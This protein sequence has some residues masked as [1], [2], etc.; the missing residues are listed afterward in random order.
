MSLL[1]Q[2]HVL[3]SPTIENKRLLSE[4]LVNDILTLS[5]R[6]EY[7]IQEKNE[8]HLIRKPFLSHRAFIYM[9]VG[10]F[11]IAFSFIFAKYTSQMVV[12]TQTHTK[13][14]LSSRVASSTHPHPS[15][16]P[17]PF[18]GV[19]VKQTPNG[20][21]IVDVIPNTPAS[22]ADLHVGDYIEQAGRTPELSGLD[23][24]VF[25]SLDLNHIIHSIP[26]KHK[27]YLTVKRGKKVLEKELTIE[28]VTNR[29]TWCVGE[30]LGS[31]YS[32]TLPEIRL[33]NITRGWKIL[34]I[35]ANGKGYTFADPV[36]SNATISVCES[37][38]SQFGDSYAIA[39]AVLESSIPP[40][41]ESYRKLRIDLY[42][43]AIYS[44]TENGYKE[45]TLIVTGPSTGAQVCVD[46]K[47]PADIYY[48]YE[49]VFNEIL[50]SLIVNGLNTVK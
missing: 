39:D 12:K 23:N 21:Q 40:S 19:E 4:I 11:I 2:L 14:A 32:I 36:N 1:L 15:I 9:V 10:I 6:G 5:L 26:K 45:T 17:S 47:A 28:Y 22:K 24:S 44:R 25:N 35:A 18:I 8:Q 3:L 27:L 33:D 42:P 7:V 50:D 20:L 37:Y 41:V 48:H 16:Y 31:Y 30:I 43:A 49:N 13:H 29:N 38:N 46:V 34:N